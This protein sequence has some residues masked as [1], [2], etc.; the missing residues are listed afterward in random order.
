[1]KLI[2]MKNSELA[3]PYCYR[4][5]DSEKNTWVGIGDYD[6]EKIIPGYVCITEDGDVYTFDATK[7]IVEDFPP[8]GKERWEDWATC[9]LHKDYPSTRLISDE[10]TRTISIRFEPEVYEKLAA[11]AKMSKRSVSKMVEHIVENYLRDK[12]F[13]ED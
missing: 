13:P 6:P 5:W 10:G 3:E 1:M 4:E 8:I 12:T 11:F 9:L 2:V 7:D